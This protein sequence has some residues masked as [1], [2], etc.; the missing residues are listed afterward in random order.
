MSLRMDSSP[1]GFTRLFDTATVVSFDTWPLDPR[2][3]AA[4]AR[5]L[6]VDHDSH[7]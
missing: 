4:K 7:A 5:L 2:A 6:L 3:I 1:I